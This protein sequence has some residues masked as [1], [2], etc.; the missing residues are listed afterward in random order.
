MY[1]YSLQYLRQIDIS[2]R[3]RSNNTSFTRFRNEFD[4]WFRYGVP[5]VFFTDLKNAISLTLSISQ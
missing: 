1:I 4:F 2:I 3:Y 5:I